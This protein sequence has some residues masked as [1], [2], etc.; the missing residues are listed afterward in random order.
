MKNQQQKILALDL[1]DRWIG[2]ALSDPLGIIASPLKTI[3]TEMLHEFLKEIISTEHTNII[4]VGYPRT[5]RGTE[6]EQ[7]KNVVAVVEKLRK[8]FPEISWVL[9]DERLSS[10]QAALLKK[11]KT[12]EDRLNS[13]SVA[14]AL[15]LRDYLESLRFAQNTDHDSSDF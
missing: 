8:T 1:G 4:V 12:K 2:T 5:L 11:E 10:K 9:W 15:I 6:S 3:K 7:T 14:A 13:H